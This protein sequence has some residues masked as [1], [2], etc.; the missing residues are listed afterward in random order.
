M[1]YII[2]NAQSILYLNF[3]RWF[4]QAMEGPL[5]PPPTFV[6][7]LMLTQ[8][9]DTGH[10]TQGAVDPSATSR[11]LFWAPPP[12]SLPQPNFLQDF[13]LP[14]EKYHLLGRSLNLLQANIH[15]PKF[16]WCWFLCKLEIHFLSLCMENITSCMYYPGGR[17]LLLGSSSC[18]WVPALPKHGTAHLQQRPRISKHFFTSKGCGRGN[19]RRIPFKSSESQEETPCQAVS[20][21]WLLFHIVYRK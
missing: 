5:I 15:T 8:G 10:R 7:N 18:A 3:Q 11:Q 14:Q 6:H 17:H 1:I 2:L 12:S 16:G 21:S 20:G 19:A 9:M 13:S 4:C